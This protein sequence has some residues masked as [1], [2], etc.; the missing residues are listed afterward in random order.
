VLY[1]LGK[2]PRYIRQK[3]GGEGLEAHLDVMAR[4]RG[5]ST[6]INVEL[7]STSK[8]EDNIVT[9]GEHFVT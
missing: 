3:A 9:V 5:F 8:E 7:F 2:G 1:S 4:D 6:R